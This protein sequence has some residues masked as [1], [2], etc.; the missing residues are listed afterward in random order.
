M[1]VSSCRKSI[2]LSEEDTI[3]CKKECNG[4]LTHRWRNRGVGKPWG[5]DISRARTCAS[6]G[7]VCRRTFFR[8]CGQGRDVKVG[9]TSQNKKK[10]TCDREKICSRPSGFGVDVESYD[11]HYLH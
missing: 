3:S 1:S 11:P 5:G 8:L 10:T 7:V 6:I 2:N 4:I 9:Y